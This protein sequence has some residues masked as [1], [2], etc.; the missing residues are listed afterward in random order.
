MVTSLPLYTY[1]K[2]G[3]KGLLY[4]EKKCYIIYSF[5][6]YLVWGFKVLRRRVCIQDSGNWVIHT[7]KQKEKA[8]K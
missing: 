1:G 2:G 3:K 5:K 4:F 6:F 8:V 7:N